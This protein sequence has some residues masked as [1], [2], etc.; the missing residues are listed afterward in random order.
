MTYHL[1]DT[2]LTGI[3]ALNREAL[4]YFS[5]SEHSFLGISIN[6]LIAYSFAP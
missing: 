6:I 3:S 2:E 4:R 1:F 5:L